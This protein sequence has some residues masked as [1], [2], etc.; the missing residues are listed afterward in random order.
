MKAFLITF[1][2]EIYCQGWE[3]AHPTVLVYA[4]TFEEACSK[5]KA[6][7]NYSQPEYFQNLTIF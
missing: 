4:D 5:I 6:D 3:S 7:D 2:C 1:M